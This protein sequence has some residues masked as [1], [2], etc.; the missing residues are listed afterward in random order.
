[1]THHISD[2]DTNTQTR[3]Q[4]VSASIH[5]RRSISTHASFWKL[6]RL[7]STLS[8]IVERLLVWILCFLV[9]FGPTIPSFVQMASCIGFHSEYPQLTQL[10]LSTVSHVSNTLVE[11]HLQLMGLESP[12]GMFFMCLECRESTITSWISLWTSPTDAVA[13]LHRYLC[14]VLLSRAS[15]MLS[16]G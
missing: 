1:M 3:K 8:L 10:R 13:P 7:P 15:P 5:C 16:E 9:N 11:L 12:F 2:V 6:S 14:L 4:R